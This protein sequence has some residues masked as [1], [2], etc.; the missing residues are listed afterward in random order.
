MILSLRLGVEIKASVKERTSEQNCQDSRVL[1][2]FELG[3]ISCRNEQY[4]FLEWY[5]A[6]L[7]WS[8]IEKKE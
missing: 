8:V 1:Q 6:C 7:G 2:V 3:V 4:E 5:V